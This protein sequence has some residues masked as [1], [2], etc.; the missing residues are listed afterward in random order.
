MLAAFGY[1]AWV[2]TSTG[3]RLP[4]VGWTETRHF[5][6]TFVTAVAPQGPA[7]NV[8]E[9]GDQIVALDGYR[10]IAGMGTRYHRRRLAAGDSYDLTFVRDGR[11]RTER[12]QVTA[13]ADELFARL[14]WDVIAA[15]WC[16]VGLF[17]GFARPGAPVA[18]LAFASAVATGIFEFQV[19]FNHGGIIGQPLHA[20]V[21][22]HF[23]IRFPT[24]R[25]PHGVWKLTLYSFYVLGA[26]AAAIGMSHHAA[27]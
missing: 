3:G 8:L 26:L 24:G 13:S 23:F 12:L 1:G 4:Y 14:P 9:P 10:P 2:I 5:E 11:V 21:A 15:V 27:F 25:P 7:G 22:Y 6:R 16:G 20:V 19:G 17:I 18:R